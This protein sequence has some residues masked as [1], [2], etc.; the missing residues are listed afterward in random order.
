[1]SGE[2][3]SYIVLVRL[4]DMTNNK[5]L[6]R[7]ALKKAQEDLKKELQTLRWEKPNQNWWNWNP[8]DGYVSGVDT[9]VVPLAAL[10]TVE[11][12]EMNKE[13]G[14]NTNEGINQWYKL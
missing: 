1:M 12:R 9:Y 8:Q 4:R 2:V 11:V 10:D 5:P 14:L 3:S 13:L 6:I 7:K